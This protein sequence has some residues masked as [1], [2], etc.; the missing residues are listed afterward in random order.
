[1]SI[2]SIFQKIFGSETD[3][4]AQ[5][6]SSSENEGKNL[7]NDPNLGKRIQAEDDGG[8]PSNAEDSSCEES[9]PAHDVED[10]STGWRTTPS[11]PNARQP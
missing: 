1:M 11:A 9:E 6:P 3:N 10:P 7:L 8:M 5:Q 2:T 4:G